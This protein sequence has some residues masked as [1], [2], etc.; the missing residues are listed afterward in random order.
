MGIMKNTKDTTMVYWDNKDNGKEHE[1]YYSILPYPITHDEHA[2]IISES[3]NQMKP[4]EDNQK[5]M[6]IL[7]DNI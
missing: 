5:S 7:K 3:Q 1:N 2:W 6:L 4:Q